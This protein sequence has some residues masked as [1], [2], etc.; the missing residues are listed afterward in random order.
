MTQQRLY[1]IKERMKKPA[2]EP[3]GGLILELIEAVEEKAR[4]SVK[5]YTP[6]KQEVETPE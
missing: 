4:A 6:K 3:Y 5:A 2:P 1:E